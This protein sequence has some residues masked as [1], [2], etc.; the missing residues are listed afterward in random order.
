M[1]RHGVGVTG[2]EQITLSIDS[3]RFHCCLSTR[4]FSQNT[5]LGKL[6]KAARKVLAV[7]AELIDFTRI[8]SFVATASRARPHRTIERLLIARHENVKK[9]WF[10]QEVWPSEY[11][12]VITIIIMGTD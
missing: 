11:V 2:P 5:I 7:R 8:A 9:V 6:N 10:A 3:A 4:K 12:H 1:P